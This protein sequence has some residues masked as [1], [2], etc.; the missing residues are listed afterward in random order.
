MKKTISIFIL[1]FSLQLS[2]NELN[3]DKYKGK[4]V[5]LDFW[6]SWCT[7]CQQSFPWLNKITKEY[8]DLVVIGVNLDKK[9][10]LAAKFL[11]KYPA[12]FKIIYNPS[13][14]LAEKYGVKGMPYSV[15]IDKKGK[16]RY[17][18]IGFTEKMTKELITNIKT[19]LEEK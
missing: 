16:V 5:F 4:V 14:N 2:A 12:N 19:L 3:L 9:K 13:A 17:S 11:K 7:P 10:K 18:H 15:M 1:L 6:A 8:K